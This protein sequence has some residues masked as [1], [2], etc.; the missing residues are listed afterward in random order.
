MGGMFLF[1]GSKATIKMQKLGNC[2]PAPPR[3]CFSRE[4]VSAT[5]ASPSRSGPTQATLGFRAGRGP[6]RVG[7]QGCQVV[8][9][10]HPRRPLS[11]ASTRARCVSTS[12]CF[13]GCLLLQRLHHGLEVLKERRNQMGSMLLRA[14]THRGGPHSAS[15][16]PV[17]LQEAQTQRGAGVRV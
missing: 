3:F 17:P 12:C 16:C 13:S 11:M 8:L 1:F 15:L 4:A 10:C 9:Q 7:L 6:T 5:P 2:R 14:C